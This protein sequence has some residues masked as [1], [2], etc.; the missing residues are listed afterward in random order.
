MYG[1][2]RPV[3]CPRRDKKTN[4][5]AGGSA[6]GLGTDNGYF[7][8]APRLTAS[9]PALTYSL[10]PVTGLQSHLQGHDIT[11][12]SECQPQKDRFPGVFDPRRAGVGRRSRSTPGRWIPGRPPH[13]GRG[14][15]PSRPGR[16]RTGQNG[17]RRATTAPGAGNAP[18]PARTACRG[19]PRSARPRPYLPGT[20][21]P[22]KTPPHGKSTKSHILLIMRSLSTTMC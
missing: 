3:P 9:L 16:E 5:P 11:R 15:T 1:P 22:Q 19:P 2:Q 21:A 8:T 6:G 20:H 14:R 17:P 12:G 10:C 4:P 18:N 7:K 13:H